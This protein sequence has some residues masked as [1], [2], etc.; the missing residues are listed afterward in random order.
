[1]T[2]DEIIQKINAAPTIKETKHE[3]YL[4]STP[5]PV[6]GE[7]AFE[8]GLL[9]A[10]GSH[11]GVLAPRGVQ[12]AIQRLVAEVDGP[13]LRVANQALSHNTAF[14]NAMQ[15]LSAWRIANTE[16]KQ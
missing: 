14:T 6:Q 15:R 2:L 5:P 16:S 8:E 12:D 1:M 7:Y 9:D 4:G 13:R 10:L 11:L 3:E